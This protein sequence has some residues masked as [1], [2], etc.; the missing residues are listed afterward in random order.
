VF[1]NAAMKTQALAYRKS[2]FSLTLIGMASSSFA[3]GFDCTKSH[4]NV[5]KM[6]C[7][8]SSISER[9]STLSRLYLWKL[10]SAPQIEKPK[11]TAD[12]KNWV[13]NTRDACTTVECL[14]SAYD[15]RVKAMSTIKYDG[16]TATYVADDSDIARISGEMQQNL[17]KV[18]ITQTLGT[19]SHVLSLD[20]HSSSYG[21]F[22]SLGSQKRVEV[23]YENLAGNLAVNFYGFSLTGSGLASFTQSVCPGG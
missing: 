7:A 9:D 11:L 21:A 2:L 18:G 12:Q 4:S 19:C 22:C 10:E 6:I 5:E 1:T 15:A 20:S 16:G 3:A 14:S 13:A 8:N 23:C 17:R